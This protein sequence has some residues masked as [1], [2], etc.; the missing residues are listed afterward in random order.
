MAFTYVPAERVALFVTKGTVEGKR[1]AQLQ[2]YLEMISAWLSGRFPTLKPAF[3][4]SPEDAPL[5]LFVEAAVTNAAR[6]IA[7]NPDGFSSETMGPFAYSRYDSEDPGKAWFSREEL[8]QIAL[9]LQG[10]NKTKTLSARMKTPYARVAKPR[11][12]WRGY[13]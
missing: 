6:K 13:R 12:D 8:E 2:A 7:Q 1:L 10:Y 4:A 5:R 3:D 9:L 11:R